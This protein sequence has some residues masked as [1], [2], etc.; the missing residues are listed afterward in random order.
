MEET[1]D[2]SFHSLRCHGRKEAA[3]KRKQNEKMIIKRLHVAS[4]RVLD[5]KNYKSTCCLLIESISYDYKAAIMV[6]S[7]G[8]RK[9]EAFVR[10]SFLHHVLQDLPRTFTTLVVR[11]TYLSYKNCK[12]FG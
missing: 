8:L 12:E 7:H 6:P 2:R 10:F 3:P 4:Y 5:V 11:S 9:K 1:D